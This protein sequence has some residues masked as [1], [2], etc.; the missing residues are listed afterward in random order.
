MSYCT[1]IPFT[2]K[3]NHIRKNVVKVNI[4]VLG[5]DNAALG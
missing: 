3:Y 5:K 4:T 2:I 1:A